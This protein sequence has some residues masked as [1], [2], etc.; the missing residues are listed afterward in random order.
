MANLSKEERQAY[1][2]SVKQYRD[3]KNA[4]DTS[5]NDGKIEGRIEQ[6]IEGIIKALRRGRLTIDEIL[7]DFEVSVD[8]VLKI[9][10]ENNL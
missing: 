10:E 5:H 9:K 8:F 6:K 4:M 1:E 7:E 2:Q 3:L